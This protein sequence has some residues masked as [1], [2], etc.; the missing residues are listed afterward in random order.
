MDEFEAALDSYG[1]DLD[2]W[3]MPVRA[4]AATLLATSEEARALMAAQKAVSAA[5]DNSGTKAPEGLVDRILGRA[6]GKH[7]PD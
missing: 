3:P 7:D 6:L 5:F 2:R 4:H 1:S